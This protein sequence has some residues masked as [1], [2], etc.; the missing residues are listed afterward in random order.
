MGRCD[1]SQIGYGFTE[2]EARRDAIDEARE[3]HGHEE[4]YSGGMN[5]STHENDKSKCLEKPVVSKR[6]SVEKKVQKGAR[7]WE[8]VFVIEP[9]WG[10]G[11][12][13]RKVLRNSTQA[14][15]IAEAKRMALDTQKE[16]KITIDKELV[17]GS[18]EIATVKPKKSQKGK[19]LFTGTARCQGSIAKPK[20]L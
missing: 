11:F 10:D 3:Y 13:N 17:T 2:A 16:Y 5:C 19:W 20:I 9:V 14:K 7:K 15:A 6:C 12:R 8:T 18:M 1:Y 4:G